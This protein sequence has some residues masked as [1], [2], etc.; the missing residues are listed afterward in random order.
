MTQHADLCLK[1]FF[2]TVHAINNSPALNEL[3]R[4][5]APFFNFQDEHN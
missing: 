3:L 4:S 5:V 1:T 2:Q